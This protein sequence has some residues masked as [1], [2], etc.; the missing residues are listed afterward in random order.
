MK[1]LYAVFTAALLLGGSAVY[2]S[3]T[4]DAA[5]YTVKEASG[6]R[7]IS[8]AEDGSFAGWGQPGCLITFKNLARGKRLTLLV[9]GDAGAVVRVLFNEKTVRSITLPKSGKQQ[10]VIPVA[11]DHNVSGNYLLHFPNGI[12]GFYFFKV[13]K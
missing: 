7:A 10:L 13:E 3:N 11:G 1:N 12:N 6:M 5:T 8:A 9:S 4:P 2:A